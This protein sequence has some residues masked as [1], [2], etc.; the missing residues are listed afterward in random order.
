MPSLPRKVATFHLPLMVES[1]IQEGAPILQEAKK[2]VRSWSRSSRRWT[3][4]MMDSTSRMCLEFW[5]NFHYT[6][7]VFAHELAPSRLNISQHVFREPQ[8]E[9]IQ[10]GMLPWVVQQL[11]DIDSLSEYSQE[12][13]AALLMNLS[14]RTA[15]K[16]ACEDPSMKVVTI[17]SHSIHS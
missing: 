9:M 6:G 13:A 3:L 11:S 14:L 12:C 5:S 8:T 16:Q 1:G 2:C 17:P 4:L 15:G 10:L 7:S